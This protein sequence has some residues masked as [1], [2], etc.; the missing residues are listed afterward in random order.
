VRIRS[1]DGRA[2][3]RSIGKGAGQDFRP[4][5][6]A[7]SGTPSTRWRGR[8]HRS[9]VG[10]RERPPGV[11]HDPDRNG[12]D[13][14]EACHGGDRGQAA[15]VFLG[16]RRCVRG[17]RSPGPI[18][19]GG[20]VGHGPSRLRRG[21]V[22]RCSCQ[23]SRSRGSMRRG[24]PQTEH[25]PP[26]DPGPS[27]GARRSA[28]LARSTV[29]RRDPHSR[30]SPVHR[31]QPSLVEPGNAWRAGVDLVAALLDIASGRPPA[32]QAPVHA[33]SPP[34]SCSWPFWALPSTI[35]PAVQYSP[36]SARRGVT[37]EATRT[38]PRS[39][40]RCVTTCATS[41]R[42]LPRHLPRHAVRPCG[43]PSPRARS[44]ATPSRQRDGRTYSAARRP[45]TSME[46]GSVGVDLVMYRSPTEI[47][48]KV[49]LHHVS[50]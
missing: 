41:S 6:A 15:C 7:R 16:G 46:W 13:R 9:G 45:R 3:V 32:V 33:A 37:A 35:T 12:H 47:Y 50:R 43:P 17:W 34:T 30:G 48:D 36:N 18:T 27:R 40:L 24:K 49:G 23:P 21:Q 26:G 8:L 28:R 22:G 42:S 29:G 2:S 11:R 4:S 19:G 1:D 20:T 5:D 38:A 25:R 31:H 44:P 14:S 39:S 10:G